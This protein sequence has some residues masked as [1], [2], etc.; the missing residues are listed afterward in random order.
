MSIRYLSR[1][2]RFARALQERI[3]RGSGYCE[4]ERTE[5]KTRR[6]V[7]SCWSL[8]SRRRACSLHEATS[9]LEVQLRISEAD[10]FRASND[11]QTGR[12]ASP[13]LLSRDC[14]SGASGLPYHYG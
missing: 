6:V 10:F 13:R 8:M 12:H 4:V 2:K 11:D 1:G 14:A 3:E 5:K 9:Q 7:E